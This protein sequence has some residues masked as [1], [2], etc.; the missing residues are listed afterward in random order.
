MAG[1]ST[2]LPVTRDPVDGF[3]LTKTYEEMIHQNFK[4][5]VLTSPGER[6]MDPNFGVGIR[7]YLFQ[8]KTPLIYADIRERLD[9]QVAKYLPFVQVVNV[10][11]NSD[12]DRF[13]NMLAVRIEYFVVPLEKFNALNVS[14]DAIEASE[15]SRYA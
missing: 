10:F 1:L 14:V 15:D 12:E 11:F 3:S 2:K 9:Q 5:L 6:V 8:Q 4:N 7:K 13:S